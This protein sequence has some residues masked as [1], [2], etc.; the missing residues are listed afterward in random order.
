MHNYLK[1]Y[2]PSPNPRTINSRNVLETK[3]ALKQYR[4]RLSSRVI[5]LLQTEAGKNVTSQIPKILTS[6][7][8]T[9]LFRQWIEAYP[10]LEPV[11]D[12]FKNTLNK[13]IEAKVENVIEHTSN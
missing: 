2:P 7:I 10:I 3:T 8:K 11:V 9:A 12:V 1:F 5:T 6:E 13:E 4:N